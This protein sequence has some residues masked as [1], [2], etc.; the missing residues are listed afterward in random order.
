MKQWDG[1]A[2]GQGK[3]MIKMLPVGVENFEEIR[4]ED[5]YYVDKTGLN[6]PKV[7]SITSVRFDEYFGF[8]DSEVR[9][10]LGM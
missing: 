1:N 9:V 3:R 8:T 2:E 5:Y 4:T 6:N 7:L 10:A